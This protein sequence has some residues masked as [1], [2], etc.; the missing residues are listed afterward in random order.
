[1]ILNK[2]LSLIIGYPACGK[3]TYAKQY[4]SQGYHRLNRDE[5]GGSLDNL[6]TEMDKLYASQ[7]ITQFVLDNTYPTKQSREK[8]IQWAQEHGFEVECNWIDADIGDALFNAAQRI[9]RNYGKL[10]MPEEIKAEKDPS[11]YPPVAIYRSRKIYEPPSKEEGFQEVHKIPFTR[12]IN[13]QKYSNK[14]YIFDYDG[15]LRTTISGEKY[16]LNTTDIQ[17]FPDRASILQ[18]L[19]A[20]GNLILGVSNMSAISSG[21]IS[22]EDAIQCYEYTNELLD[23]PIDYAFCPHPAFPQICYCRKPMPGLGVVFIEKYKLDPS[24]CMMVG[25]M[26][27]DK[28]FTQRC[29][30]Q[31]QDAEQFFKSF[32]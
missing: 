2:R 23:V 13:T 17:I 31:Y 22:L 4:M 3:T 19:H 20:E 1:M 18:E 24:K 12:K 10:L 11:V 8:V 27:T 5:L 30:F 26:T 25:D 32:I 28:T 21:K 7:K 9:I 14:A 16:P 29:G 6:V 15:T